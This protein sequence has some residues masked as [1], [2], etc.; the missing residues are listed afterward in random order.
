VTFVNQVSHELKTPLTSIRMY[1][2]LLDREVDEG[3]EATRRHLGIIVSE[4]QRLSRLIGN[5]LTFAR[6]RRGRLRLHPGP[7]VVDDL[8]GTVLERFRPAMEGKGV[9]TGFD[10]NAKGD[11]LF[12]GDAVE[13]ILG[14]LFSNVE[15]YAAS[16]G[17]M[18]VAS[19]QADGRTVISVSDR[20]PGVP[21]KE[22]D[23]IFKP[24]YRL[25]DRL[26]D[27]VT[28][29][30][31]GLSISRDLARRHGGDLVLAPRPAGACFRVTLETPAAPMPDDTKREEEPNEGS[32]RR[33]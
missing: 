4:S 29:T 17:V 16:G 12:D 7:G 25:S 28:G 3:D 10:G 15:K 19:R 5:I 26:S 24:F 22:R 9:R 21:E 1:A 11:V 2:E 30:G 27:G 23:R 18:E 6:S 20:G 31:I 14:N 13:Q 8:I 32:D 33:G